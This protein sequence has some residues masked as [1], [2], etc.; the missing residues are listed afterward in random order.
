MD[1]VFARCTSYIQEVNKKFVSKTIITITHRDSVIAI[2]K[3]LK[4]FDYI[5]KKS[6]Y[7]PDNG[8]TSV[9]YRDNDRNAEMDLHKPYIDS[10]RF[11]KGNKEY[12]RVSE[13]MDCWFESGSMPFGQ[14]GYTDTHSTKPLVYPAD[15]IMEGLD[16]T[17]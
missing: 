1:D 3:A 9:R 11:K 7:N 6:D 14:A 17:R 4:D 13:V 5:T 10:Y 2:H 8:K 15:F 16:Q 12:R